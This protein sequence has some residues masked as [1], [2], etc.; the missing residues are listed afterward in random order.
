MPSAIRTLTL[1]NLVA[2]PSGFW[3]LMAPPS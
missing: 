3:A 2:P 1:L